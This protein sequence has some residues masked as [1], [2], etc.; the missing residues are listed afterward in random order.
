L[1]DIPPVYVEFRG[2]AS[3]LTEAMKKVQGQ[4]KVIQNET[5]LTGERSKELSA[6]TVAMGTVMAQVLQHVAGEAMKFGKE[7]VSAYTEI[8]TEVRGLQRVLG[9]T[10]EQ[11]S[12]LRFVAEEVGVDTST[13]TRG[14]RILSTHLQ[15]NDAAAKSLGVSYRDAHGALLPTIDVIANLSD[16]FNTL[17]AGLQRTALAVSMFG[18]S[19]TQMLPLLALG[20]ERIKEMAAE[21]DKLGLTLSGKDLEAVKDYTLKQRELHA[22]IQGVQLSVGR[23]LV[24]S[25]VSAINYIQT[26]VIPVFRAFA[27]G[28]TGKAG[29]VQGLSSTGNAAKQ[30]GSLMRGAMDTVIEFKNELKGVAIAAAAVWTVTKIVAAARAIVGAIALV[31]G[32]YTALTAS[33]SAAAVAE[34]VASGGLAV[35]AMLAAGVAVAGGLAASILTAQRN[36]HKDRIRSLQQDQSS[37][38]AGMMASASDTTGGAETGTGIGSGTGIKTGSKSKSAA[39]KIIADI[40]AQRKAI[41]AAYLSNIADAKSLD[42]SKNIATDFLSQAQKLVA[43][44]RQEEKKTRHTHA[45]TAAVKALSAALQEQAKAQAEVNK[46]TKLSADEIAR[47][48][49]ELLALN[50]SYTASNSWLAAQ[51]RSAGPQRENFGGFIEVPV[52]IDGQVVFRATQKYSLL[53]NRRNVANGMSVSGSLI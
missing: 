40:N 24:P 12:R 25:L 30:M 21:A 4:F 13:L 6:K 26:N 47:T 18:R 48:N 39:K 32:A 35:P 27:D 1:A 51:M 9:G 42:E 52:A 22:A 16:K 37:W 15:A 38:N 31:T 23:D 49:R 3:Q 36:A 53:N 20:S 45:H 41:D 14:M 29:T 17:P 34:G 11:M 50:S 19:G 33:A 8:G 44:A 2:D 43:A 7:F 5:K 28:L 46:Y 10:A